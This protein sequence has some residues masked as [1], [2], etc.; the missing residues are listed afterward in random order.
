VPEPSPEERR[1]LL[2]ALAEARGAEPVGL[3]AW[4]AAGLREAAERE[5]GP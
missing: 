4:S 2:A 5:P 1:A 3:D